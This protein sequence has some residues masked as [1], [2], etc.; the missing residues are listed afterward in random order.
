MEGGRVFL[1]EGRVGDG[2]RGLDWRLF[3]GNLNLV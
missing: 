1:E 2:M 3:G